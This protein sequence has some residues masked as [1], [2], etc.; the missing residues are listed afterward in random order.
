MKIY[1]ALLEVTI[2]VPD[3]A[4][5]AREQKPA[6]IEAKLLETAYPKT[7]GY[8]IGG[9]G[10]LTASVHVDKVTFDTESCKHCGHETPIVEVVK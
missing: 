3:Y 1:R 8:Q 7:N 2:T 10:V 9:V 5:E 6:D 4:G